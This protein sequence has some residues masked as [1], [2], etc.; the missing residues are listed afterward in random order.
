MEKLKFNNKTALVTGA[1]SGLGFELSKLLAKHD[2]DLILV[3][4]DRKNLLET[5]INIQNKYNTNVE[6]LTK[7]LSKTNVSQEIFE[8][9]DGKPIDT[10][11]IYFK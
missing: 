4:V 3:D 11:H 8:F 6:I 7:D 2:Y 5:R 9:V 10:T 1:A